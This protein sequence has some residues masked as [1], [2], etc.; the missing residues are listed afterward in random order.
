MEGQKDQRVSE[1][2]RATQVI[3]DEGGGNLGREDGDEVAMAFNK[4]DVMER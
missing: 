2:A 4:G 1:G 3:V